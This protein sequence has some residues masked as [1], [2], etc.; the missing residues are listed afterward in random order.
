MSD[1]GVRSCRVII[2]NKI[3][4][5]LDPEEMSFIAHLL[6]LKDLRECGCRTAYSKNFNFKSFQLARDTFYRCAKRLMK[7]GLIDTEMKGRFNDYILVEKNYNRLLEIVNTTDNV[8]ALIQFSK[9]EFIS[10]NRTIDMITDMEI[11][12][13]K[14]RGEPLY[15][16]E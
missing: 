4:Y 9:R 1:A 13:L 10:K 6:Y 8:D 3:R 12:D 7:I 16:K 15:L 11:K 2:Y 14:N 5:F